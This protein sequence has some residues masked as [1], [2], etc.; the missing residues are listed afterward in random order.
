MGFLFKILVSM[1]F[2]FLILLT[3]HLISFPA[4]S[5]EYS[6]LVYHT[7]LQGDLILVKLDSLNAFEPTSMSFMESL[8]PFYKD[9]DRFVS[10]CGIDFQARPD[11]YNLI[12]YS[13]NRI[14]D[15]YPITVI[16]GNFSDENLWVNRKFLEF[17]PEIKKLIEEDR[18]KIKSIFAAPQIEKIFEADFLY[19]LHRVHVTS[20]FGTRRIYNNYVSARHGGI[21]YRAPTGTPVIASNSGK[22]EYTGNHYISGKIIIINHGIDIFS[23]YLH[24]SETSV[25]IGDYVKKGQVIGR[26]GATGRVTGPHLD[27]RVRINGVNINPENILN[28]SHK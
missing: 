24:L 10:L 18:E 16:H 1:R 15:L 22:V 27:F 21:D 9:N 2:L 5:R 4:L 20:H 25:S 14:I 17:P 11:N 8:C 6:P 23:N 19:P 26:S 13:F 12:I 3:F 28:L 7:K